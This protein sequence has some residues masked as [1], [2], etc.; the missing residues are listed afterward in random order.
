VGIKKGVELGWSQAF[1]LEELDVA[2]LFNHD[3]TNAMLTKVM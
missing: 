3:T 2:T 1:G